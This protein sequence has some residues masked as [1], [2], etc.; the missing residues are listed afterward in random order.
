MFKFNA[1]FT[2]TKAM[3][4]GESRTATSTFTQRLSSNAYLVRSVLLYVHRDRKDY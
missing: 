3:R 2:P 4:D 1:D